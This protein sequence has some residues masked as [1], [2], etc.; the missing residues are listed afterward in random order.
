LL[1]VPS[2]AATRSALLDVLAAHKA[3]GRALELHT[4]EAGASRSRAAAAEEAA[5]RAEARYA[6]LA[7][8]AAGLERQLEQARAMLGRARDSSAAGARGGDAE[9]RSLRARNQALSTALRQREAEVQRMQERLQREIVD[10]DAVRRERDRV[11]MAGTQPVP[12]LGSASDS[13]CG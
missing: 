7:K 8:T 1:G 4:L 10:R 12:R 6:E 11:V 3:R 2:S 13:R 9:I 5:R